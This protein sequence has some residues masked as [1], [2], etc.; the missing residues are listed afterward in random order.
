MRVLR[1]SLKLFNETGARPT[2]R[3]VLV[4][5][6][7]KK[8]EVPLPSITVAAKGLHDNHIK[9]IPVA[10]GKEAD[11]NQ[12]ANT[13]TQGSNLIE[14]PKKFVPGKLGETIMTKIL[15]GM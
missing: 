1:E 12:L 9:V 14:T 6:M 4:V 2:A 10:V 13:T 3:R 15:K 8:S 7:D 5:I 11:V